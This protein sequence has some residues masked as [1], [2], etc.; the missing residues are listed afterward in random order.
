MH[1]PPPNRAPS[2]E[3]FVRS[4]KPSPQAIPTLQD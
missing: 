2:I 3:W 4:Q 1:N